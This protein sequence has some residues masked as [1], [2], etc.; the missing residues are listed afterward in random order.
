MTKVNLLPA[1]QTNG[2]LIEA[3]NMSKPTTSAFK[4]AQ[5]F[6]TVRGM[7]LCIR[8]RAQVSYTH[9]FVCS[10]PVTANGLQVCKL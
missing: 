5:L 6:L 1:M 9:S 3:L 8:S 4:L 2:L 10:H 7:L